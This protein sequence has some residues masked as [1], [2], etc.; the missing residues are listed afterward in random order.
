MRRLQPP[1]HAPANETPTVSTMSERQYQMKR[2]N[3][4]QFCLCEQKEDGTEDTILVNKQNA[5]AS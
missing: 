5:I 3:N 2:Y 1:N 4:E